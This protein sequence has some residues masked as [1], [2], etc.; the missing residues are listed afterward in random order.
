MRRPSKEPS[1]LPHRV[2][3]GII[4][5]R[6]E[7]E[8]TEAIELVNSGLAFVIDVIEP[9]K[10]TKAASW[11]L[12]SAW[13]TSSN[14]SYIEDQG[15]SS[16]QLKGLST[17]LA[18]SL[19]VLGRGLNQVFEGRLVA[20]PGAEL[21]TILLVQK[22]GLSVPAG[23]DFTLSQG[24][25]ATPRGGLLIGGVLRVSQPVGVREARLILC[26]DGFHPCAIH[27]A[28]IAEQG[29]VVALTPGARAYVESL[30][31]KDDS[32]LECREGRARLE[33]D[34]AIIVESGQPDLPARMR[35]VDAAEVRLKP[36][37][38]YE[39]RGHGGWAGEPARVD[40]LHNEG[41]VVELEGDAR[42]ICERYE[43]SAGEIR[44]ELSDPHA[45]PPRLMLDGHCVVTGGR[46]VV[47]GPGVLSE[48]P[49]ERVFLPLVEV[50][51][52]APV[53]T[54]LMEHAW[55]TGFPEG[56]LTGFELVGNRTLGL[57]IAPG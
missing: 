48:P 41:G 45:P 50:R 27:Q 44:F 37:G 33:S 12:R 14:G 13:L 10:L 3:D 11:F 55:I 49:R 30:T 38:I 42:L 19:R 7:V 39:C 18:L 57:V 2:R 21:P 36:G 26:P 52:D 9:F 20:E 17:T 6:N 8:Y 15:L 4:T 53:L 51:R 47:A 56:V 23:T 5:I 22:G 1:D 43:Q 46:L 40:T 32:V 25:D 28:V 35:G 24:L 31:L 34:S 54:R 29:S 16:V